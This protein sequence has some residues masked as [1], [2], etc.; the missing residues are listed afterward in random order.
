MGYGGYGMGYPV[1]GLGASRM[2]YPG[3]GWGY[4]GFY[5]TSIPFGR[6][7]GGFSIGSYPF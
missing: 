4:P 1:F 3:Y 6:P 5:G 2:G 7:L